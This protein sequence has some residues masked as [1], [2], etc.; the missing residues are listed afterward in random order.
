MDKKEEGRIR[1]S[2]NELYEGIRRKQKEEEGRIRK[3]KEEQ[4]KE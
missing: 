3:K 1:T 4:K 2:K